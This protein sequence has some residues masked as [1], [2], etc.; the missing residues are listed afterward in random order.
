MVKMLSKA[1]VDREYI[2]ESF[3]AHTPVL[4]VRWEDGPGRGE[5][6]WELPEGMCVVGNAPR[7]LGVRIRRQTEDSY[8]VRLLWENTQLSW[9]ALTRMELLASCLSP[10]LGA[11]GIDLW[12]L[13][14]QPPSII[15]GWRLAA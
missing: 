8:A 13:L 9:P 6:L 2:D 10:V 11:L 4:V 14:E 5:R 15:R 7:R 1:E 12:S 3:D